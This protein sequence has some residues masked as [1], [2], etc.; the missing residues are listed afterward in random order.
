MGIERGKPEAGSGGKRGH[1]HMDPRVSAEGI[2]N[3]T[4]KQRRR[5]SKQINEESGSVTSDVPK[6]EG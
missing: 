2:K 5:D 4:R 3:F 6:A 1:S